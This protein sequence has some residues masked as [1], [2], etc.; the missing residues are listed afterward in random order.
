MF[1]KLLPI[2]ESLNLALEGILNPVSGPQVYHPSHT[3]PPSHLQPHQHM[4]WLSQRATHKSDRPDSLSA[5][6]HKAKS[7]D[8]HRS[9]EAAHHPAIAAHK[10]ALDHAHNIGHHDAIKFHAKEHSRLQHQQQE[11]QHLAKIM[12]PKPTTPA[13]VKKKGLFGFGK[14]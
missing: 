3:E 13:P 9:A 1:S 2:L 11:H 6:A 7:H 5:A 8:A 4:G 14:K 10:E 12:A